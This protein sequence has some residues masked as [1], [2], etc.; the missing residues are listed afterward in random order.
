M[1]TTERRYYVLQGTYMAWAWFMGPIYPLFLLSRGLDVLQASSVLATYFVVTFLFEVPTGAVADLFGRRVSFVLACFTRM[2]AF[3]LYFFATGYV[4]C[5]IAEAIDAIGTTLASGALD[6]WAVDGMREEGRQG[7]IDRVF[8]RAQGI[9]RAQ[10]I[11]GGIVGGFIADYEIAL[12]WLIAAVGFGA[13]GAYAMAAMH[14][15]PPASRPTWSNA[16]R[17]IAGIMRASVSAVR[18]TA[19][20]R[21]LC[22]L[23]AAAAIGIMPV[24][25]LWP[26]RLEE[27]LAGRSLWVFGWIWA[28]VSGVGVLGSAF[29]E[30]ALNRT[31]REIVL[32]ASCVVRAIGIAIAALGSDFAIVLTGLLIMEFA[33]SVSS[34]P[35]QAWLN[36]HIAPELRATV[37]SVASMSFTIG[38]ATGLVTLGWLARSA[39]IPAAWTLCACVL[40]AVAPGYLLLGRVQRAEAAPSRTS[41]RASA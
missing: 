34:P 3:A 16:H 33:F 40:V 24:H 25:F 27:L 14:E 22:L 17:S 38:G 10:M 9:A 7:P 21:L 6:A 4:D 12:P 31:S 19:I 18:T 2:A 26:A 41:T 32:F 39:G 5:L 23:T 28:L 35:Y 20:V 30:R 11:V 15:R 37:L 29:A 13:T 8:A 36:E 1:A